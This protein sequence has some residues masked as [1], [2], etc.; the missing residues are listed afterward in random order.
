MKNSILAILLGTAPLQ[1]MAQSQLAIDPASNIQQLYLVG[2]VF[3]QGGDYYFCGRIPSGNDFGV[4][5]RF[6]ADQVTWSNYF[7]TSYVPTICKT[8]SGDV[9]VGGENSSQGFLSRIDQDGNIVWT[10]NISSGGEALTDVVESSSGE[11]YAT[12]IRSSNGQFLVKLLSTGTVVW[13]KYPISSAGLSSYPQLILKGDSVLTFDDPFSGPVGDISLRILDSGGVEIFYRT[14]G[15]AGNVDERLTSVIKTPDG[16]AVC[17]WRPGFG[18]GIVILDHN[19][20]IVKS[21]SYTTPG[22]DLENGKLLYDDGSLYLICDKV[23]SGSNPRAIALKLDTASLGI[24]W[25]RSLSSANSIPSCEPFMDATLRVPFMRF[26]SLNGS[27]R[28]VVLASLDQ[29]TGDFTGT[30]CESPSAI[31]VNSGPYVG[32]VQTDQPNSVW[33]D[34]TLVAPPSI[35]YNSYPLHLEDCE[36][37]QIAA[38]LLHLRAFLGGPYDQVS[39]MMHDS[40][41]AQGLIYTTDPYG[42]GQMVAPSVFA[43]EGPN[44]IVDWVKIELRD[45]GNPTLVLET[46]PALLQRDGDVKALDGVSWPITNLT[47]GSYYISLRHRNH[48]G[49]CTA[50]PIVPASGVDFTLPTTSVYGSEATKSVGGILVMWEGDVDISGVIKYVGEGNDRDPIL[51]VVGGSVPTNV[52]E[53]VYNNADVNMDGVVRYV[54]EGNDRDPILVNIGGSVPTNVRVGQLP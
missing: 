32:L 7:G 38:R 13:G 24:V 4:V 36:P 6:G 21:R 47:G 14:Y 41:R 34:L 30:T 39:G 2:V 15:I 28:G 52:S 17:V 23:V 33:N 12:G 1:F 53:A 20:D 5:T 26:P 54:G 3:G 29:A 25:N 18:S 46:I 49:V 51:S 50:S 11:I 35:S 44:A 45:P 42:S 8:S 16:Y 37:G 10:S 22:G 43:V 19:F 9:V 31:V 40:L 48:L 27:V